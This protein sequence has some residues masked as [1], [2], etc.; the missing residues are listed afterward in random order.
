[1]KCKNSCSRY[2]GLGP[3]KKRE[4]IEIKYLERLRGCLVGVF[5][6]YNTYSHNTFL[7]TR[8][9]EKHNNVIRI[10]FPNG[11]WGWGNEGWVSGFGV[12]GSWDSGFVAWRWKGLEFKLF[13]KLQ[14]FGLKFD[15]FFFIWHLVYCNLIYI[16]IYWI[17]YKLRRFTNGGM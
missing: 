11:Q 3:K 12:S 1:M 15:W 8:I 16:N 13:P 7:P 6:Q 17:S 4:R 5:K 14:F 10:T 2:H 9:F